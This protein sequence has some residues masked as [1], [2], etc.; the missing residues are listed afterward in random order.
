MKATPD[1]PDTSTWLTRAEAADVLGVAE[2]T[3]AR[4][5]QQGLLH[6]LVA[7]R[8]TSAGQ[9]MQVNVYNPRELAACPVKRTVGRLPG[10]IAARAFEMF[11]AGESRREV[12]IS[13]REEPDKIEDLYQRWLDMGGSDVVITPEAR[14]S[15]SELLGTR[16]SSVAELVVAVKKIAPP[17]DPSEPNA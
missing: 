10:D 15:L 3:I 6:P 4:W 5:A 8:K 11:G 1:V 2:N 12:V 7:P 14:D 13:T 16:I 9:T 17:R